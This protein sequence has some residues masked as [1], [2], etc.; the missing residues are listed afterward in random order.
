MRTLLAVIA[1]AA[2]AG[3]A[4]PQVSTV[5][6]TGSGDWGAESNGLRCRISLDR[7]EYRISEPVYVLVEVT[8]SGV[9]PVSFGWA[10]VRTHA[11][12]G[13]RNKPPFFFS[14][15]MHEFPEKGPSGGPFTLAPG[16][17]WRKTVVIRPWGPTRS[18]I[19]SVAGPGTMTMDADFLYRPDSSSR[20]QS[21]SSSMRSF[22][23]VDANSPPD[24]K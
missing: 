8:N 4:T 17:V 24:R 1:V 13:N 18:S 7:T 23:A 11:I 9:R 2:V 15:S 12:Q 16:Q 19:P 5:A 10:E 6:I 3:C 22:E 14:T 20:G 21:V